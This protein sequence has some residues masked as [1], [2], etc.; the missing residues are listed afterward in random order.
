MYLATLYLHICVYLAA[1][2][3]INNCGIHFL[4][5]I[6]VVR[7][8][9]KKKTSPVIVRV[10]DINDNAPRFTSKTYS[11]NISEVFAIIFL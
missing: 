9:G 5:V 3:I 8:T 2:V 10:S 11:T 1:Y 6:C 4:Q 7:S